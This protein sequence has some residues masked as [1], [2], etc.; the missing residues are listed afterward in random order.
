MQ[1]KNRGKAYLSTEEM[2]ETT[3][4]ANSIAS[5]NLGELNAEEIG[6]LKS[7]LKTLQGECSLTQVGMCLNFEL[8]LTSYTARDELWIL[9]S[10]VIDHMSPNQKFL[11]PMN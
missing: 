9:D 7:F 1:P 2:E 5:S 8:S 10:R 6:K 3:E 11:K 4:K